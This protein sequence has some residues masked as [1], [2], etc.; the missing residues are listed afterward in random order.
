[1]NSMMSK[2]CAAT[3]FASGVPSSSGHSFLI[4]YEHVGPGTTIGSPRSTYGRSAATLN[5][6]FAFAASMSPPSRFGIPQ[7]SCEGR[8]TR[9]PFFSS[10]RTVAA[11]TC[12]KL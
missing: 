8:S 9:N 11:A 6:A 4:V 3:F 7:H 12:G 10:T 5:L 2:V 1:M